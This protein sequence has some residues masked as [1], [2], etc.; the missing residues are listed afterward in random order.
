MSV[1]FFQNRFYPKAKCGDSFDRECPFRHATGVAFESGSSF[2]ASG[3]N[4]GGRLHSAAIPNASFPTLK[5]WVIKSFGDSAPTVSGYLPGTFYKRMWRPLACPGSFHKAISEEKLTESFVALR[6]LLSKLESLFETVEPSEPNL[7]TYGHKIREILLLACMEVES[8]WSAIL[9]ENGYS[10]GR[11]FTTNDYVKLS[12]PML[13]DGYSLSLQSYP[14]FPEFAPF[15]DWNAS[16]PTTSLS[17][18]DAYNKTKHDREGNLNVG[19]LDNAVRAV[20]AAVVMFLAQFGFNFGTGDQ[21]IP[22]IR[23]IFRIGTKD[24]KKYEKEYYIPNIQ[25]SEGAASWD[26]VALDYKF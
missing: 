8:S 6:I 26:W 23:N 16:N 12:G 15:K 19:T 18:Y 21:K 25:G 5:E 9:K 11:R 22:L 2:F 7:P 1:I 24:L 10:T 13:L 17:W 3:F 4:E 14:S 20:G